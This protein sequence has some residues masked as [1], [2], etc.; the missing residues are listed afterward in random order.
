MYNLTHHIDEQLLKFIHDI[1]KAELHCHIDSVPMNL[2][3][4]F[5]E[6]NN[7]LLPFST[8]KE[9][10]EYIWKNRDGTLR[11]F[12]RIWETMLKSIH[13]ERDFHDM[14][15][16]F[17]RD[18]D[19]QHIIYR[20]AMFSYAPHKRRGLPL[21][22][23]L[24]GLYSG[25]LEAKNKYKVDIKFIANIDRTFDPKESYEYVNQII[26][27]KTKLPIIAFGLDSQEKGYPAY[28]HK[29]AFELARTN[30]YKITAHCGEEAGAYS[31]WDCLNN[32][33]VNRID[34]GFRAEEDMHLLSHLAANDILLTFCPTS[35]ITEYDS[36]HKY[37]LKKFM[38]LGIKICINSDDPPF[39]HGSLIDNYVSIVD[40]FNLKKHDII[41]LVRNAFIYNYGGNEHLRK[42][43]EWLNV[44]CMYP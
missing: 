16:E 3:L 42:V 27:S 31:V 8:I 36:Y 21:E 19:N 35:N 41:N 38:E 7:V 2:V 22:T 28:P 12:L 44:N 5:A 40:Y 4:K 23:V 39:G 32:I 26:E 33:R 29:K 15:V 25:W 10:K 14:V 11:G 34:H 24:N 37:P 18:A 13:T 17:A 30:G 1:P 6:R 20:E 43:D 9:G